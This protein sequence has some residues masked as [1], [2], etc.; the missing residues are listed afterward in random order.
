MG[1][2]RNTEP[3]WVFEVKPM[4][5]V[6]SGGRRDGVSTGDR[7]EHGDISTGGMVRRHGGI[8]VRGTEWK[9]VGRGG[10]RGRDVVRRCVTGDGNGSVGHV[11]L[12]CV[13]DCDTGREF[14]T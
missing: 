5:D 4:K 3:N 6:S 12:S 2:D 1:V 7:H 13:C 9:R 11:S 8:D 14:L 10:V